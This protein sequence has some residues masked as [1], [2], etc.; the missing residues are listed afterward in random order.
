MY[1]WWVFLHIVGAAGFLLSH[2][3]SAA[4]AFRLRRERDP[5]KV[6]ALIE[7]SRSTYT[8]L[9]VSIV[10]LLAGGIVAGFVGHWWGRGWIWTALALMI[11]LIVVM[12][13]VGTP[14]YAR[15]L[16][17]AQTEASGD[18]PVPGQNVDLLLRSPRP[19]ILMVTGFGGLLVILWLMVLKPF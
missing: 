17:A 16:Q 1:G 14:Y 15:V 7:L 4:I 10:L 3:T 18:S 6:I 11:V 5:N 12:G 8:A 13:I 2:G 9:Y 19:I